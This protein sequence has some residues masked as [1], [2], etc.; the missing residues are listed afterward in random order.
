EQ[1]P[2]S[3]A[4]HVFRR[5]PGRTGTGGGRW[6]IAGAKRRS[7]RDNVSL[8]LWQTVGDLEPR[9]LRAHEDVS[10]RPDR[11][12]VDQRPHRDMD[13]GALAHHRIEQR[14]AAP[15]MRVM[16]GLLA[17]DHDV[18]VALDDTEFVA[19]DAGERL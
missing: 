18:V 3:P 14:P 13:E 11:R 10:G 17:V 6:H 5:V 4:D 15:A 8:I 9:R 19:R 7:A 16:T 1:A 2:G 12:I